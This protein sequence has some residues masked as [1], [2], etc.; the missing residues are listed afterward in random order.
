M[1][2]RSVET[3]HVEVTEFVW[4]LLPRLFVV[5]NSVLPNDPRLKPLLGQRL[6]DNLILKSVLAG[7]PLPGRRQHRRLGSK[8]LPHR[9]WTSQG[10]WP[11]HG[12]CPPRD[13]RSFEV[14]ESGLHSAGGSGR[15]NIR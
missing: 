3:L 14:G 7:W 15:S 4:R 13:D 10:T 11:V 12:A 9:D 2:R 1:Y 8:L 6:F 5:S